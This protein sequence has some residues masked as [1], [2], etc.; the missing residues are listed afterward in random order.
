MQ[1]F[2]RTL[3][4]KVIALTC[5]KSDTIESIKSKIEEKEGIRSQ[6]QRF[7]FGGKNLVDGRTLGDYNVQDQST[8]NLVLHLQG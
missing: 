1:I 5:E 2:V 3:A 8:L 7:V 6:D 4:G